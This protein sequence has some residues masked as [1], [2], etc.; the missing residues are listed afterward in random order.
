MTLLVSLVVGLPIGTNLGL[1]HLLWMLLSGRL[2]YSRG[3]VMPGLSAL[4]L[5]DAA[6]W[7]AWAALG[8]GGLEQQ[9]TGEAEG[10]AGAAGRAVA[11][12]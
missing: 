9:A 7:R 5:P 11:A 6:V 4:G 12:A 8:G 1:L 10:Q 2:L 3:A